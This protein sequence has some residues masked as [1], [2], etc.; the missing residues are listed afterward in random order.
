MSIKPL[1]SKSY[2]GR[3]EGSLEGQLLI[4]M[5]NMTDERFA[6]A[7]IYICAHSPEGAMGIVLNKPAPNVRFED[8]LVQLDIIPSEDS[9]N[10]HAREIRVLQGGPIEPG[11]GFVL[12]S[13]D[14]I[15]SNASLHI[16]KNIYLTATLDILRAIAQGRGPEH[17]SF[18]L[19]YAGWQAGQLENE[20]AANSWLNCFPDQ[21]LIFDPDIKSK[22]QRSLQKLGIDP[23][24][25]SGSAGHA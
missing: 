15:I 14:F 10:L 24:R 22:Y 17:A 6:Q 16:D 23:A 21:N 9:I 13:D 5:P 25:L 11:R 12:H 2:T 20:I 1:F 18:A 4:A 19:G 7:V 8:L 3:I